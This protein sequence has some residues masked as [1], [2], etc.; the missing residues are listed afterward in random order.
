MHVEPPGHAPTNFKELGVHYV[1]IVLGILTALGLEAGFE[2]LHHRKLARQTIE[3][4]DSELQANLTEVRSTIMQ[5]RTVM[6][7]VN[8]LYGEVKKLAEQE[9]AKPATLKTLLSERLHISVFT[10]GLRR[11]AWDTALADQALVHLPHADLR[12]LS[13]A[14]TAQRDSQQVIQSSFSAIGSFTRLTDALVD[15][16]F[17]RGDPVDLI[18]A[19][20]AYRLTLNV[21]IGVEKGL[22]KQLAQSLGEA[23][24]PAPAASAASAH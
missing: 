11:D 18:K 8:A 4:V 23:A 14:Y 3:Q 20:H 12:R 17:G 1:M 9:Q 5:N 19:L 2:A 15:A 16:E 22:E 21:V 10:P 24:V 7:G 13:E 6:E